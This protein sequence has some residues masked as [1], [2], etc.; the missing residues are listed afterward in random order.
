MHW[1]HQ[2]ACS[3]QP[4]H[5]AHQYVLCRAQQSQCAGALAPHDAFDER[6]FKENGKPRSRDVA[7]FTTLFA[8]IDAQD[9]AGHGRWRDGST[10][11][12]GGY[13]RCI[14]GLGDSKLN[15][16]ST[17]AFYSSRSPHQRSFR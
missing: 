3:E 14:G 1:R 5:G 10:L 12:S 7:A 13:G 15:D 6:I 16:S 4:G 17:R 8:F 2:D 9:D 11:G